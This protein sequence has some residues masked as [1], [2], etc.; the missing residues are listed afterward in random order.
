MAVENYIY[1][2]T[3]VSLPGRPPRI[4]STAVLGTSRTNSLS[5]ARTGEESPEREREK[6]RNN[7]HSEFVLAG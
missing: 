4:Q 2:G 7:C 3:V 6:E 5:C 1:P